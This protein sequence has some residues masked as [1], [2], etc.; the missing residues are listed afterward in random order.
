[1]KANTV[2][3]GNPERRV[4]DAPLGIGEDFKGYLYCTLKSE[5]NLTRLRRQT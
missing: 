3:H 1:M 2:L 5:W 4:T